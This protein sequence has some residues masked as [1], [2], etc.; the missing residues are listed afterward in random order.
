MRAQGQKGRCE[1]GAG[2]IRKEK[3]EIKLDK[4]NFNSV[5]LDS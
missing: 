4:C 3:K 2:G 5:K 1:G